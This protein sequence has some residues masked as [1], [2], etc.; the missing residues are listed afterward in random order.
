MLRQFF[1]ITLFLL[2]GQDMEAQTST[3]EKSVLQLFDKPEKVL[4]LRHYNGAIDD[5]NDVS[6]VLAYDGKMCRG[7]M[8]YLKSNQEFGLMGFM[9]S[10]SIRLLELDRQSKVSGY[11]N[12]KM[13]GKE[14]LLDW[15]SVDNSIGSKMVLRQT[16]KEVKK[17]KSDCGGEKWI[18]TFRGLV[19]G[20]EVEFLLQRE[21]E[22]QL[23]G[24]VYFSKEKQSYEIKGEMNKGREV[25]LELFD[26]HKKSNG[27]LSGT[28]TD[29][30]MMEAVFKNPYG[31]RV[32]TDFWLHETMEVGCMTYVDYL[33]SL[34]ISY[35]VTKS[36]T[37]NRWM[38]KVV[39]EEKQAYDNFVEQAQKLGT[40]LSPETRA[41]I[42]TY[43]WYDIDYLSIY[44]IS[45]RLWITNSWQGKGTGVPIT[46]DL[47]NGRP[48][49]LKSIFKRDF[50]LQDFI[51]AYLS[52]DI[53]NHRFYDN[54]DFRKWLSTASF[55]SFTIRQEGINFSTPFSA[56]YGQQ[57]VT[58][59]FEELKEHMKKEGVVW[60]LI[61]MAD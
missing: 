59:P 7:R 27:F 1:F 58:I 37:F 2:V 35:P 8:K 44:I 56:I 33:S 45:G 11:I 28:L 17:G 18:R 48:V 25:K 15:N 39:T 13:E 31:A 61:G 42:R 9:K 24:L 6:M 5:V 20:E 30:G 19:D 55:K 51:W 60:D 23:R 52:Q 49:T 57:E 4:W 3:V 22:R 12:G 16:E 50:N 43:G 26:Y 38:K 47:I 40:E 46:Y 34:G 54:Y 10:Q 29:K 21:T 41:S 36:K 53:Q 32:K 14:L